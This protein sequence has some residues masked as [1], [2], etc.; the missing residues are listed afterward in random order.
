MSVC[1]A[2][3]MYHPTLAPNGQK[4]TTEAAVL[5]LSAD[6]VDTPA[7]FPVSGLPPAGADP[8]PNL[9]AAATRRGRTPKQ[10]DV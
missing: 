8:T 1:V 3:F 5:A 10:E 6:W 2:T 4:F 7:K 9:T